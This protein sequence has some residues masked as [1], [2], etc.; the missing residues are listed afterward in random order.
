M[1]L[2]SLQLP[3]QKRKKQG[4]QR[5]RAFKTHNNHLAG[6]LEDYSDGVPVK[7]WNPL[8]HCFMPTEEWRRICK[9]RNG[10]RWRPW[11]HDDTKTFSWLSVMSN[12]FSFFSFL[13]NPLSDLVLH[14]VNSNCVV[15]SFLVCL[16][17]SDNWR[18]LEEKN[19]E[20]K[21]TILKGGA[22]T[23]LAKCNWGWSV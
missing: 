8:Q 23:L 4:G 18:T 12:T 11:P 16:F 1:F 14:G 20:T 17:I 13:C 7:K 5:K 21:T 9:K 2:C 3:V 22:E 15:E 19:T 6:V 10:W